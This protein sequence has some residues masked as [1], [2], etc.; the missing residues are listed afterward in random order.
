MAESLGSIGTLLPLTVRI[1]DSLGPFDFSNC[2]DASG[3]LVDFTGSTFVMDVYQRGSAT[4]P[5]LSPTVTVIALGAYRVAKTATTTLSGGTF[6]NAA[7]KYEYRLRR[8]DS[9]GVT[10]TDFYGPVMVA[11]EL[12]S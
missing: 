6:L 12:P 4:T 11:A 3:A 1:G 2:K 10:Q 8:T 5:V 9:A 7:A